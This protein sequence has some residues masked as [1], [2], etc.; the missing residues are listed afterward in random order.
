MNYY[1]SFTDNH[2]HTLFDVNAT[3]YWNQG[4][5]NYIR[6][7][8]HVRPMLIRSDLITFLE[9]PPLTLSDDKLT[10]TIEQLENTHVTP[11][12]PYRYILHFRESDPL[13]IASSLDWNEFVDQLSMDFHPSSPMT[14]TTESHSFDLST[15]SASS[16]EAETKNI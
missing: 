4:N 8:N 9:G 10:A 6:A 16:P 2:L 14:S 1:E 12:W 5:H 11:A 13:I 15:D 3:N 7:S